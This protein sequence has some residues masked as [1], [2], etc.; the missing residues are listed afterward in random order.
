MVSIGKMILVG[1]EQGAVMKSND[2]EDSID[3]FIEETENNE[4]WNERR[5]STEEYNSYN[6]HENYDDEDDYLEEY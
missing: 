3:D 1:T 5:K 4:F 6:G 2:T